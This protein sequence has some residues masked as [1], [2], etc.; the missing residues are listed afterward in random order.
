MLRIVGGRIPGVSPAPSYVG[1]G[2]PPPHFNQAEKALWYTLGSRVPKGLL[3]P[4]DSAMLEM[5][6]THMVRWRK[7]NAA[8]RRYGLLQRDGD[9]RGGPQR[10][11]SLVKLARGEAVLIA[12]LCTALG[13]TVVSRSGIYLPPEPV[14]QSE[15]ERRFAALLG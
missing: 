10:I 15:E 12:H 5:L 11:H 9:R 14:E 13:L 8:V 3:T 2:E 1:P 4:A 6:C 7:A